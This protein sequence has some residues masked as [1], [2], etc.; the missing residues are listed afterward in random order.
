RLRIL[1]NIDERR[2]SER[3]DGIEGEV[4]P[5]LEPHLSSNVVE[6]GRLESRIGETLRNAC[7][8]RAARPV[9][10][11]DRES[12]AL[13]VLHHAWRDQLGGWV[14]DTADHAFGRNLPADEAR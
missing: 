12:I 4:A 10:L 9:E 7:N 3:T 5:K 8:A 1:A 6:D 14:H 13:D 11:P 2:T